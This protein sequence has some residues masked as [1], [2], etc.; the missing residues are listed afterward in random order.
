MTMAPTIRVL[1]VDD[2]PIVRLTLSRAIARQADMAVVGE[3]A[4]GAAAV[5][6][7]ERLR[8]DVVVM[9][10][11]MPGPSGIETAIELRSRGIGTPI[12]FFTGDPGA[13]D[14][15]KAIE[16]S[17]VLIKAGG[18]AAEAL[19]AIRQLARAAAT[20]S[21]TTRA[22]T[23]LRSTASATAAASSGNGSPD[24]RTIRSATHAG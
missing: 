5:T 10:V 8:P 2:E 13:I 3:A 12:L 15:A 4:D 16:A 18:G 20:A 22:P 6:I 17:R 23:G 21:S 7:V 24:M 14:R 9:D 19:D 1:I 11:T